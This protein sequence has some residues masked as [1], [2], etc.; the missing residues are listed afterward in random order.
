MAALI[1][2]VLGLLAQAVM[3]FDVWLGFNPLAYTAITATTQ[4]LLL[5][6]LTQLGLALIYE[7]WL[8]QKK[9]VMTIFNLP[10]AY[11][12]FILFNLGLPLVLLG[13][14]GLAVF[15]GAWLGLVA[16]LGAGIQL[17][18]GLILLYDVW[19]LWRSGA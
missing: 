1:Y 8:G 6:W 18:A 3:V 13:Q 5:G 17:L 4:I 19:Q 10:A 16:A 11:L 2:L 12:V 7:R 14:P 15:G 9:P